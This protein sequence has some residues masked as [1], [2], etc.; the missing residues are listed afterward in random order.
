[1]IKVFDFC[2]LKFYDNYVISIINEG[3]IV[4]K[5]LSDKIC[6]TAINYYQGKPFVYITHRIHSYSVDPNVYHD[7]SKI[8]NLV[9]FVVVSD[10][11]LSIKNAILE[12]IFLDKPFQIFSNLDDAILW[13]NNAYAMHKEIK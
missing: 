9:G 5:S 12:K 3:V 11:K 4:T 6:E 8:K 2:V 1:M 10:S 7:V 13:A